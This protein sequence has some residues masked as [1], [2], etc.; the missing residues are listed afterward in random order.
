MP[1]LPEV[2]T[3]VRDLRPLLKGRRLVSVRRL[4]AR[5]DGVDVEQAR[6]SAAAIKRSLKETSPGVLAALETLTENL[7]ATARE[8]MPQPSRQVLAQGQIVST[9]PMPVDR[10]GVYAPGGRAAYPSSAVMALVPAQVAG[11]EEIAV[12]SP[13]GPDG[14]PS[15]AVLAACS[16]RY[17][18][19]PAAERSSAFHW[20]TSTGEPTS[21]TLGS[22][23]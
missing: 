2:E 17:A 7:R 9:R 21:A 12:C 10:A 15:H 22:S 13:P 3:V 23:R 8:T 11:V 18:W 16:L 6:V 14:L 5:L 19:Y 4:T 20:L 1:E